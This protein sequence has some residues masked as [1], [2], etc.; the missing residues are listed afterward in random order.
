MGQGGFHKGPVVRKSRGA[1][2]FSR[3]A[4]GN[5]SVVRIKVYAI[6]SAM[7]KRQYPRFDFSE[8]VGY[9]DAREF[10]EM[11]SLAA[12]ISQSGV[13]L[14]VGEFLPLRK[15]LDL[16][17]HL[18]NPTRVMSVRGQVMWVRE[19]P[20]SEV[21]DVGIRFLEIQNKVV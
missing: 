2:P 14:R 1:R 19:V 7:E 6:L 4:V 9:H 17:L 8:P 15:V 18:N 5:I 21:F 12:D 11:G 13:R 3:Q 10:P 20:H 16:K